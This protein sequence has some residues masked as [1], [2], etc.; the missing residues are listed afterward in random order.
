MIIILKDGDPSPRKMGGGGE[1]GNSHMKGAG[2]LVAALR[3]V[4]FIFWSR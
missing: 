2:I 4:N 1:G 3:G